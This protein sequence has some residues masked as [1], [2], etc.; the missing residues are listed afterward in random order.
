MDV[1]AHPQPSTI[2]RAARIVVRKVAPPA[3]GQAGINAMP[4]L[5]SP[6]PGQP[7]GVGVAL[8]PLHTRR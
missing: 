1:L 5:L 8:H 3:R 6:L 4:R 2:G 7:T